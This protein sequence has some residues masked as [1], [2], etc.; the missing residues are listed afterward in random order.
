MSGEEEKVY[1]LLELE[2]VRSLGLANIYVVPRPPLEFECYV[3]R[4]GKFLVFRIFKH[5]ISGSWIVVAKNEGVSGPE[6]SSD[7]CV[8]LSRI[9][10]MAT[11]ETLRRA[12]FGRE[13]F[14]AWGRTPGKQKILDEMAKYNGHRCVRSG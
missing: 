13:F 6:E 1:M 5:E 3:F 10:S 11:E 12:G 7:V 14:P 2:K 4:N 9:E 8:L